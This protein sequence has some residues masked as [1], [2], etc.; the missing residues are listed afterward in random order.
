MQKKRSIWLIRIIGLK[1]LAY[2]NKPEFAS[3]IM[4][5]N[6]ESKK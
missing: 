3:I 4:K 6:I 5:I 2:K 1:I